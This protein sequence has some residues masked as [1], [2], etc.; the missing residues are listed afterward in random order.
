MVDW[1]WASDPLTVALFVHLL[2]MAN[3]DEGWRWRGMEFKAGQLVTSVAALSQNTGLTV[4]QVR[5]RLEQLEQSGELQV[6]THT[7]Y[8]VISINR[9][10]EY[11]FLENQG[12]NKGQTELADC[13][14]V[15]QLDAP[16]RG[17]QRANE[18]QTKSAILGKQRANTIALK[19]ED[20]AQLIE[21]L[22]QTKGKQ[23]GNIQEYIYNY[24]FNIL[25]KE[26]IELINNIN[27]NTQEKREKN[28]IKKEQKEKNEPSEPTQAPEAADA[29][30]TESKPKEYT[31]A[32]LEEMFEEFRKAYRGSKRGLT[33]ELENLKK[34]NPT[35]WRKIIPLLM[36]ALQRMEAWR[37]QE[38]ARAGGF[39]PQYAMLQTWL[40]QKRWTVEYP[41]TVQQEEAQEPKEAKPSSEDYAWDGGFGGCDV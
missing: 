28:K 40:N 17:K 2:L 39:V 9:Y 36:P 7:K 25:S 37:E 15:E 32:Q 8:S 33:V 3:S 24:I 16:L 23:K 14:S 18:G 29:P 6:E 41:I 1:E 38:A 5:N 13:E 12:A 22:G 34:K 27:N 20:L 4:K 10:N 26:D 21:L 30:A 35:D 19:S 11:Q 31:T